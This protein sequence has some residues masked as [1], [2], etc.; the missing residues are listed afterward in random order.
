MNLSSIALAIW[1]VL[2][3]RSV[4][5]SIIAQ[6]IGAES[7]DPYEA[8]LVSYYVALESGVLLRPNAYSW[9]AQSGQSCGALQL[10]CA[11]VDGHT[12][13]Q[14]VRYWLREVRA[15]HLVNLDSSPRRA[16]RRFGRAMMLL[17]QV[18]R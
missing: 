11:F 15:G 2:H 4:D 3:V 14:Q 1:T 12:L 8:A 5:A 7:R 16:W 9:D 17:A 18:R 13:R 6:A 10:P